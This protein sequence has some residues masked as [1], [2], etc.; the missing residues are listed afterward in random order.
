MNKQERNMGKSYLTEVWRS[1]K[2]V[3]GQEV[4][5]KKFT[6]QEDVHGRK[7]T[8]QSGNDPQRSERKKI[9][10]WQNWEGRKRRHW[11]SILWGQEAELLSVRVSATASISR[12]SHAFLHEDRCE[13][14]KSSASRVTTTL[15]LTTEAPDLETLASAPLG[16]MYANIL[17][18][19]TTMLMNWDRTSLW[20]DWCRNGSG[21]GGTITPLSFQSDGLVYFYKVQ[22]GPLRRM[23]C[24]HG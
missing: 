4:T 2:P 24:T 19:K 5:E 15:Q 16:A 8:E 11:R 9:L 14:S 22:S 17:V 23:K 18:P 13:A 6:R 1:N 21:I 12:C 20:W 10:D 7:V 3:G